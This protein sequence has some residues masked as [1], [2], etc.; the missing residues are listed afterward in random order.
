MHYLEIYKIRMGRNLTMGLNNKVGNNL[1]KGEVIMSI[2][3]NV[4]YMINKAVKEAIKQFNKERI[5]E[6]SRKVFH[7]TRLL[8]LHYNDLNEHVKNAIDSANKIK[9]NCMELDNLNKDE[10]YILS[11][12]RSK[13]KTLIM[14]AHI[15][16]SMEVLKQ[17]QIKLCALEKYEA[18]EMFYL[19]KL[20]YDEIIKHFNCGVNTPRRWINDMINELSILLFGIDGM[21]SGVVY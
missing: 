14:L 5:Q 9:T 19:G 18:L 13:I 12:K 6:K 10:I 4:D 17:K 8:L 7:N 21:K 2:T 3:V 15:D 16:M 20:S 11:L 1:K